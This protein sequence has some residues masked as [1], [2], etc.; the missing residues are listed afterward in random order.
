MQ[1]NLQTFFKANPVVIHDGP[2]KNRLFING[3]Q[4]EDVKSKFVSVSEEWKKSYKRI[5]LILQIQ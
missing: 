3:M 4:K 2:N 1:N 5:I